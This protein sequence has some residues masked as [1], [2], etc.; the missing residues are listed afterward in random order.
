MSAA[1][2]SNKDIF[3]ARE[4][5]NQARNEKQ[6]AVLLK[7]AVRLSTQRFRRAAE[8]SRKECDRAADL[9]SKSAARKRS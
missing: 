1:N 4:T 5:M 7:E 3:K 8:Q 2:Q 6:K 9:Q